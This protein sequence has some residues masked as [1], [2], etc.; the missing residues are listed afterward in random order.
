MDGCG[1]L[2]QVQAQIADPVDEQDG[3]DQRSPRHG[4]PRRHTGPR[5]ETVEHVKQG[6][7]RDRSAAIE[8]QAAAVLANYLCGERAVGG[9]VQR[10]ERL[11]MAPARPKLSL[12]CPSRLRRR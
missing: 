4:V 8:G 7:G 11:G 6:C 2:E 3:V 5:Q 10:R 1:P 9:Q 12:A